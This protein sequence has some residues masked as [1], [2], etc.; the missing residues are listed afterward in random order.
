M[1]HLE[2]LKLCSSAIFYNPYINKALVDITEVPEPDTEL[3]RFDSQECDFG[4]VT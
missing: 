4:Q 1:P 3:P 2:E